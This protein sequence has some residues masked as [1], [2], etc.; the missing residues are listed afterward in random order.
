MTE[1]QTKIFDK[2]SEPIEAMMESEND[3]FRVKRM[4][5]V[6]DNSLEKFI[7][8]VQKHKIQIEEVCIENEELKATRESLKLDLQQTM[9]QKMETLTIKLIQELKSAMHQQQ[10]ESLKTNVELLQRTQRE[11][12]LTSSSIQ[13]LSDKNRKR[14]AR[15]GLSLVAASCFSCIV[16]ASCVFYF[17]PQQQYV[18]YEMNAEQAKQMLVGKYVLSNFKKFNQEAQK[19]VVDALDIDIK[20]TEGKPIKG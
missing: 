9:G 11:A 7:G 6:I 8:V 3:A 10:T 18:R 4:L 15:R 20:Q 2:T 13:T 14:F 5:K 19:L 17:F 16:T 12:D 1:I